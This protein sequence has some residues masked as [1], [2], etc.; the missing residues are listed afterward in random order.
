MPIGSVSTRGDAE[1][2][3]M[4][5][6]RAI[7]KI[8]RCGGR[9]DTSRRI[10]VPSAS[11]AFARSHLLS[12]DLTAYLVEEV[13]QF[14]P[15]YLGLHPAGIPRVE[16][17]QRLFISAPRG[18]DRAR[19]RRESTRRRGRGGRVSLRFFKCHE[20]SPFSLVSADAALETRR[21]F[22]DA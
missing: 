16:L 9:G 13:V 5:T 4:G 8:V 22:L 11:M 18:R 21:L 20:P 7:A 15:R 17:P 6:N 10:E 19:G 1:T 14:F 3:T 12:N 2:R